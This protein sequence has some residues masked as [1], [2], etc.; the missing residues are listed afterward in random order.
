MSTVFEETSYSENV[1]PLLSHL[2][3]MADDYHRNGSPHQAIEM[4]YELAERNAETPEGKHA[5]SRLVKIAEEYERQG[6]PHEARSIYEH[7]LEEK[8]LVE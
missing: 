2:L 6:M 8:R 3:Q 5:R 4:Y 1:L 7:L